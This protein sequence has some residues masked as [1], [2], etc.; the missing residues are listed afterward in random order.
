MVEAGVNYFQVYMP[1]VA[2]DPTPVERF[3]R[4]VVPNFV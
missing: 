4:E 2:Y 3:A 1:R